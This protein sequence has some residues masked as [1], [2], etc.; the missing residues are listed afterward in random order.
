VG[1]GRFFA[2]VSIPGQTPFPSRGRLIAFNGIEDGRPV[3]FAHVYGDE[4]VPTSYTLPFRISHGGGTFSTT[5]ST[6]LPHV[7]GRAGFITGIQLSLHRSYRYHGERRS[8]L[9]AGCPAPD[10]INLAPFDFVRASFVFAKRTLSSVLRRTCR[11]A[12]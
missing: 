3:I 9:S 1:E 10:G 8:Y 4:P 2:D 11:A 6:S 5:L 7:T 12:G